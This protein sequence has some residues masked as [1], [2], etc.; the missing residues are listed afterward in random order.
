MVQRLVPK[1]VVLIVASVLTSC[2][3]FYRYQSAACKQ[4]GAAYEARVE[5]LRR[6]AREKL[7]IGAKKDVVIRFFAENGI[8]VSFLAGEAT[9]TV[10]TTGCAPAGC[11]S[12]A[13]YLGLRVKVDEMGTVTGEPVV[14]AIYSDCL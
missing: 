9:G 13:A 8:P 12:D 1:S 10:S 14:G 5:K 7:I 6:D 11:G 4:R 2:F 3:P